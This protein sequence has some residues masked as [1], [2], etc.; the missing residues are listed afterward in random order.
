MRPG[1]FNELDALLVG[2]DAICTDALAPEIALAK[3]QHIPNSSA[4]HFLRRE[5]KTKLGSISRSHAFSLQE[6]NTG[7]VPPQV[8]EVLVMPCAVGLLLE[9]PH[10]LVNDDRLLRSMI[11]TEL[12]PHVVRYLQTRA[13]FQEGRELS[14]SHYMQ[15]TVRQGDAL[16]LSSRP[17]EHHRDMTFPALDGTPTEHGA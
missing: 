3:L 14:A 11:C 1:A 2:Q 7:E 4:R 15:N 8:L 10:L 17:V 12:V 9:F 6:K 13:H 5:G 16:A